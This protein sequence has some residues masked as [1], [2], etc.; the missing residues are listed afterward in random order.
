MIMKK[1]INIICEKV[2]M[3]YLQ[4]GEHPGYFRPVCLD[5]EA[6]VKVIGI[7]KCTTDKSP[8]STYRDTAKWRYIAMVSSNEIFKYYCDMA[9]V[10]DGLALYILCIELAP[11]TIGDRGLSLKQRIIEALFPGSFAASLGDEL[12]QC[13]HGVVAYNYLDGVYKQVTFKDTYIPNGS[14]WDK[15]VKPCDTT[16]PGPGY[17]DYQILPV[18]Y[19][20]KA[21]FIIRAERYGDRDEIRFSLL[22]SVETENKKK[23]K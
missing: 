18:I 5:D 3:Y 14:N 10:D 15:E 22:Y 8:W 21:A 9:F 7:K 20:D 11:T 13:L 1:E 16:E 2:R 6:M 12:Q 17:W 19:Q 4:H 23:E